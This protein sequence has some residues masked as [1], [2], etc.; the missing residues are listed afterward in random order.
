MSNVNITGHN[1]ERSVLL[2]DLQVE[3]SQDLGNRLGRY[4]VG[5]MRKEFGEDHGP[6]NRRAPDRALWA[7]LNLTLCKLPHQVLHIRR[8]HLVSSVVHTAI[9]V[10]G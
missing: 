10:A 8:G 3:V 6:R 1:I 9:R 2:A 7:L 5:L 4:Y